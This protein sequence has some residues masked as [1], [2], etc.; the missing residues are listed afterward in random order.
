MNTRRWIILGVA[1]A[2]GLLSVPVLAQ[3]STMPG[4]MGAGGQA[5][6]RPLSIGQAETIARQVLGRSGYAGLAPGHIMEF[7]N[8]FYVAVKYK[9]GGQGAFEFLIDRYTG[10]VHPEPQSMMW[11]TRFGHMAGTGGAG[12]SGGM[13]GQGYG[14]GTTGPGCGTMGPSMMGPGAGPRIAGPTS[15]ARGAQSVTLAQAKALAQQFLDARLAG[16]TLDD[17]IAFP[18]YYTLDVA[19]DGKVIGMLSVNAYSGQ[20]WYH[21]WHGTFIQEKDLD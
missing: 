19:R 5:T 13:M 18:G 8:N 10:A 17:A 20:V 7:S 2:V 4:H 14:G 16:T 1:A 15:P 12:Y 3:P 6:D 11:N 21:V 9:V